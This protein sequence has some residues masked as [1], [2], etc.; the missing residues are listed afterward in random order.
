MPVDARPIIETFISSGTQRHLLRKS[1]QMYP[2]VILDR[3]TNKLTG[4]IGDIWTILEGLLKFKSV[5]F[6][7]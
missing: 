4:F 1:F 3:R 7:R 5:F 2:F 6:L